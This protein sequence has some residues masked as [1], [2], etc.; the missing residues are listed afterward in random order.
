VTRYVHAIVPSRPPHP[1]PPKHNTRAASDTTPSYAPTCDQPR[2]E[3]AASA[4]AQT[5]LCG[6]GPAANVAKFYIVLTVAA[7]L[8]GHWQETANQPEQQASRHHRR[9]PRNLLEQFARQDRDYVSHL[10]PYPQPCSPS[11]SET[12]I[13]SLSILLLLFPGPSSPPTLIN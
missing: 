7:Q 13:L 6:K 10:H 4:A 1:Q 12:S 9:R 11:P 5:G 8:G 2:C 3:A